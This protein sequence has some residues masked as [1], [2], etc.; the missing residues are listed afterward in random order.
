MPRILIIGYGN[1]LR[2]DDGF[3]WQAARLLA[4][5]MDDPRV[6][7]LTVQQLTPE[8]AEPVSK[9]DGVIFIDAASEGK[10]GSWKCEAV[11]ENETFSNALGHHFTPVSL[12]AYAKAVF[13]ASP[14]ALLV[15]VAGESFECG[16]TLSPSVE[17]VLPEVVLHIRKQIN[18]VATCI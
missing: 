15:S 6:E 17:A 13:N 14:R 12:L 10:P 4:D 3:G 9:A 1:P 2:G 5:T 7:V 8:L 11:G 16:E 18:N